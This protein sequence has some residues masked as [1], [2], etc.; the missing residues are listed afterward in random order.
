MFNIKIKIFVK[1]EKVTES[2]EHRLSLSSSLPL[3]AT[4]H[5]ARYV[6][7]PFSMR[8]INDKQLLK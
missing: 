2:R 6:A 1:P 8:E 7:A 4:Q 5:T 3:P